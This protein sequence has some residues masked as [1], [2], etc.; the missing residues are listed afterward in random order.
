MRS[1]RR[2]KNTLPQAYSAVCEHVTAKRVE[3]W[4]QDEARFGQQGTLT[5][6][7]AERGGRPRAYRQTEYEWGYLFGS[8]CPETGDAHGCLIPAA[9]R[10]AMEQYLVD[11]SKH[12]RRSVH[13][14]LVL[15]GAGWHSSGR[16]RIPDNVTLQLLPAKSPELNPAEQPWREIK[17]LGNRVVTSTEDLD[18]AVAKAWLEVITDTKNIRSLCGYDWITKIGQ[19]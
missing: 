14:L 15:D 13:A 8:V 16:L 11:F 6:V 12:L 9:N 5:R 3:S 7:W 19:N 4:F 2:V 17:Y 18:A 10:E 1:A